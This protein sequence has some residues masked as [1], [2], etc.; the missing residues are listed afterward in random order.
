MRKLLPNISKMV[1]GGEPPR[2]TIYV[3]DKN[4]PRLKSYQDSVN[5]RNKY[6]QKFQP[7]T[8]TRPLTSQEKKF[9]KDDETGLLPNLVEYRKINGKESGSY[10][11]HYKKPVQPVAYKPE[12][13]VTTKL[14]TT[15]VVQPT[16]KTPSIPLTK[17]PYYEIPDADGKITLLTPEQFNNWSSGTK[18]D[19]MSKSPIMNKP[20]YYYEMNSNGKRQLIP[21]S[22]I[23]EYIQTKNK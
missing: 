10:F 23:R 9:W 16:P 17:K 2:K 21:E 18:N 11:G 7:G 19:L 14:D 13:K 12:P 4:D 22:K 3:S 5:V 6:S 15:P 1:M 8:K 20:K